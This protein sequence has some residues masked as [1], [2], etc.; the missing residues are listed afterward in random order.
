MGGNKNTLVYVYRSYSW[1]DIRVYFAYKVDE[2]K[3]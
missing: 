1:S 3:R 2:K